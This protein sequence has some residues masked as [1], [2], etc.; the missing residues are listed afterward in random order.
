M[1]YLAGS[2]WCEE[3]QFLTYCCIT[4]VFWAPLHPFL[5]GLVALKILVSQLQDLTYHHKC[6][7]T[8]EFLI[9]L[10]ILSSSLELVTF[11]V[12]FIAYVSKMLN[13]RHVEPNQWFCYCYYI[14]CQ[15]HLLE[16]SL[17]DNICLVHGSINKRFTLH[18]QYLKRSPE[19][20]YEGAPSSCS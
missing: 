14:S 19:C 20:S 17:V 15:F 10:A 3:K 13:I 1:T 7:L 11:Y 8:N 18:P 6:Q 2:H 9:V 4:S 5:Y 16:G 12:I